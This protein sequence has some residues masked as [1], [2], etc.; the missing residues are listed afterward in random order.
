[1]RGASG[2]RAVQPKKR[3][4]RNQIMVFIRR[5]KEDGWRPMSRRHTG[6]GRNEGKSD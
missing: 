4:N 2:E 1:M 6:R 5:R 3:K